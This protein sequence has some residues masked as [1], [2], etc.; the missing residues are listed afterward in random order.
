MTR[1]LLPLLLSMLT[2]S[3]C[4]FVSINSLIDSSRASGDSGEDMDADMN[5][6]MDARPL[7]GACDL[8][9]EETDPDC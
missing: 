1:V 4:G 5:A 6:D 7:N 9:L 3:G 2:L 8:E